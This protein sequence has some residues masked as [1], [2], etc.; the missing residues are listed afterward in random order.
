MGFTAKV[1]TCRRKNSLLLA[2]CALFGVRARNVLD[3]VFAMR[4]M[5]GLAIQKDRFIIILDHP[6]FRPANACVDF[7]ILVGH[8]GYPRKC[9]TQP[10]WTEASP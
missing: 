5:P 1:R 2:V 6:V 3:V 8:Y 4:N 10:A 9:R 7:S